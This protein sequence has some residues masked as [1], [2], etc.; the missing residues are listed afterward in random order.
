VASALKDAI[1]SKLLTTAPLLVL[2]SGTVLLASAH[3]NVLTATLRLILAV[4]IQAAHGM[5]PLNSVTPSAPVSL[6][7]VLALR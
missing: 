2:A 4:L 1:S 7:L 5:S 6:L 3:L